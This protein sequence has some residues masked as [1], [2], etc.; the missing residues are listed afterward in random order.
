MSYG[1]G[2][3]PT[4]F[5]RCV[6]KIFTDMRELFFKYLWIKFI[7]FGQSFYECLMNLKKVLARL[8]EINLV[9]N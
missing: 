9:L 3:A 6:M 8:E 7:I 5:Q 1:L 4:T 2:N